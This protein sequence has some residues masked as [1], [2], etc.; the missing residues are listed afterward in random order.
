MHN[1]IQMGINEMVG[2]TGMI[3]KIKEFQPTKAQFFWSC[4][5]C[6]AATAIVGFTLGGWVTGG[7]AQAMANK[8]AADARTELVAAV[9]VERFMTSPGAGAELAALKDARRWDRGGMIRDGGWVTLLGHDDSFSDAANACAAQLVT[10]DLAPVEAMP[11]PDADEPI[12][13]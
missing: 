1:R 12:E 9:C 7:T 8:A 10:M 4:A 2:Q 3:E 11:A 5:G 13:G 6:V